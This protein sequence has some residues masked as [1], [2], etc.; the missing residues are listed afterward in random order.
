M[1]A[2]RER[3]WQIAAVVGAFVVMAVILWIDIATGLWQE[4]VVLGGVAAG[5]VT[6]VLTV[7]VLDRVVARSTSLRWE[8]L[9]RLAL[10]QFLHAMADEEHSEVSRGVIHPR[11]LPEPPSQTPDTDWLHE[12]R[13]LV[14][15][16]RAQ[17]AA[18]LGTW[19]SFLASSGDNEVLL[20]RI[21]DIAVQLDAVRDE[22]LELE[23][24]AGASVANLTQE[25]RRCND[26][27][28]SLVDGIEARLDA[29]APASPR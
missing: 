24:G 15:S 2:N 6:F 13:E 3:V 10:T 19:S 22:S 1:R 23:E 21:A 29:M 18:N 4:L 25:I 7:L 5:L 9:T 8:P 16:E 28:R 11:L 27:L 12:L 17:L 26:H 20:F 14:V